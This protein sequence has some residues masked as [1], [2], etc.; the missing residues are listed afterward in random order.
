[1]KSIIID[2]NMLMAAAQFRVDIFREL[3]RICLFNYKL[4]IIDKTIS[5]L[6]SIRE[7]QKGKHKEAAKLALAILKNG[8]INKIASDTD[9]NVDNII[10]KIADKEDYIVATL[11]ANLKKR[12]KAK[13][14]P[15]ITL[16]QKKF[17][18]FQN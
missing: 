6:N 4:C 11:D 13:G 8:K 2:T 9:D 10:M 18:I 3:E 17:L 16:R 1:M 7:N 5:E 15:I 14:V 12:L